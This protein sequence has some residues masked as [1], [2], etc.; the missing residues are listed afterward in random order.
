MGCLRGLVHLCLVLRHPEGL[1]EYRLLS[2]RA[3]DQLNLGDFSGALDGAP[4]AILV[5]ACLESLLSQIRSEQIR[6]NQ[7][8]KAQTN[9]V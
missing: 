9:L 2:T 5:I 6:T 4:H 8:S 7:I 3:V 1:A